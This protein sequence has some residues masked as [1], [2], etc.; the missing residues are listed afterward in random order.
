[1]AKSIKEEALRYH[2]EGKPGKIEVI[3]TKPYSTQADL[4]LA[5]SPGVAEPCLAIE[6]NPL[7]AYKYTSKGNLVAV[8]SN[9]TAVLGLGDIGAM[10]G[11]P[12]MEGKG[13]LFKIFAGIDVFDIEVDEKDPEKFIQTV[14]A[15]SPTFGG[16]N[17]EDIKAPECFEIETRL[18]AELDIPV[19]HDDQHG[20]AIISGAGLLNALEITGRKIEDVKIVVNG[21]GAASISCT[22][23]YVLLG[24]KKENIIMCDSKG[25]LSVYRNNLNEAKKEF[26][27]DKNIKTLEEAV[28]GADVFLGLSVADVLTKEMVRSMN[29]NP[30]VFALANPNPEISY[31]D[32]MDSR[33]DIIFATGRSDYPNQVNN[34]LGFP[35]IFRGA[36]D[37]HAKAINEEMKLAAVKAIAALAKEP[38]PDV[39]NAAYKLKRTTFGRDYILPKPLDPRLLTAVSISV[40]KAA[41]ESGVA[42]K[43]ITDW[44]GYANHLRE[45]MGYD[46]K[47]IRSFVD[48]A[49][50]NPKRVVFAEANHANMLK[51][52]VEAKSEGIC[53]PILLGNEER[54]HKI[55]AEENLNI[56]GIEIVNLRHDRENDRRARFAKIF[57]EQKAREGVTFSEAYEKMVDRNAFGM[58]MVNT[59]EA[60]AFITG[61]YSRYSEVIKLAE[62]IIGIR[63]SY[64]HFGT[65][66]IISSKKGTFFIA[67][68]LINRHPSADVLKDVARLTHDAVRFFAHEPVMAMLSYSNFG[69]DKQGSPMKVHEAIDYLHT[70]Y[71]EL[72]VDGEMQVNFA[73]DKKLRDE[74]YPFNKLKGKDVNTL[75]FPNLSSANSA[76][77]LLLEMGVG[78]SIGPIQ[79]GLNKPI[80]F[81]DLESSTRDILNLTT[82]A[83]VDAIVQEQIEKGNEE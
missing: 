9:G 52:A 67:D 10:S 16:I 42:R 40:A 77:K 81:T 64:K 12:V 72:V 80:H 8:I 60:D 19:M 41:I 35:Y 36:L 22:R 65:M 50:A 34:V 46:N 63:P 83:V 58:M 25:V 3:P 15:I 32:A 43:V 55:A 48:M 11:K 24:A 82:V 39:V 33:P 70:N 53:I 76:Y 68:T 14:K 4:S 75:I 61:V 62:Q 37:T 7:D 21:A 51:A 13:L 38:V 23:L 59:G 17:L 49:K 73:F 29:D 47:L 71:P 26:A 44:E 79:M 1:M 5:Y 66:N 56:D 30:I 20:T 74:T 27:T 31:Q 78:E 57:S 18:K 28:A 45:M 2:A 54:L 6:Q 69:A